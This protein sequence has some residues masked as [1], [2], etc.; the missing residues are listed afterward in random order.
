MSAAETAAGGGFGALSRIR[1]KRIF[2]PRGQAFR[3]TVEAPGLPRLASGA[4]GAVVRFSRGVGLPE[5]LPDILGIALRTKPLSDGG[6]DLLMVTSGS[7]PVTRHLLLPTRSWTSLPYST[8]LAYRL[9]DRTLLF[10]ARM[11]E[12]R[13]RFA[14]LM[15]SPRE[16]WEEIGAVTVG[17]RLADE[18]SE[19]LRFSP[20][21]AGAGIEPIGP[22]NRLRRGAY[23]A[24]QEARS[25]AD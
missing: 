11:D 4:G 12:D 10:G 22:L 17:E 16:P 1:G 23:P 14:L 18:E 25:Q 2:H 9:E 8:I 5:P 20:W 19:A 3:A 24:S 15:A 6:Q 13:R 21:H 7:A